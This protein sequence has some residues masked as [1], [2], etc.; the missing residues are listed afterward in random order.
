MTVSGMTRLSTP[1]PERAPAAPSDDGGRDELREF[2]PNWA[3][4][5]RSCASPA[6]AVARSSAFSFRRPSISRSS[7]AFCSASSAF[8]RSSSPTRDRR[9]ATSPAASAGGVD[10]APPPEATPLPTTCA[11]F[12][13]QPSMHRTISY[14]QSVVQPRPHRACTGPSTARST[15]LGP[16]SRN[17]P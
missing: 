4:R 16:S 3:R 5:S 1:L 13:R 9:A 11:R 10:T 8:R 2:C 15:W 17:P 14:R 12:P 6:A 7:P